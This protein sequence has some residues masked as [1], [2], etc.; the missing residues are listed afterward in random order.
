MSQDAGTGRDASGERA[1]RLTPSAPPAHEGAAFYDDAIAFDTYAAHRRST[2][3]ANDALERPL[4]HEL[5]GDLRGHDLLDLGCGDAA[6]GRDALAAGAASYL[7]IDGSANM[8]AAAAATLAGTRGG[9]VESSIEAWAYPPARYD[10]VVARLSLHYVAEL[11]SV[12]RA[13]FRTLRPDGRFVFSVEHPLLTACAAPG[14]GE[15]AE[16]WLVDDYFASGRRETTW[17]KARVVKY[18]RTVQDHFAAMSDAGFVVESLRESEPRRENFV[19]AA[20]FE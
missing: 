10:R 9:V 8:L 15:R 16:G 4:I 17:M 2:D 20:A 11:D 1:A 5:L 12:C 14:G 13:V 7:G 18:H 19:G 3:S 6:L